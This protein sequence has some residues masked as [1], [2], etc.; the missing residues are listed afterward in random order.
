ML[1]WLSEADSSLTDE[2]PETPA[3]V[4]AVRAFK[5]ALFGTPHPGQNDPTI[6]ENK[7]GSEEQLRIKRSPQAGISTPKTSNRLHTSRSQK[8][9]SLVSPAKGILLTPGTAA[10]R[11]K[12]VSFSSL[13]PNQGSHKEDIPQSSPKAVA[14]SDQPVQKILEAE[15]KDTT[16]KPLGVTKESF[17]AQLDA[18]KQRLSGHGQ[19]TDRT[20]RGVTLASDIGNAATPT[21]GPVA[22]DN[23]T[24]FTVDL[25]K[26]RSKSGQYWKAEHER[27]QKESSRDL[28]RVLRRG[29]HVKSFAEKKDSE[30]TILQE[31]LDREL[32][33]C[34]KMESKVSN[35]VTQLASSKHQDSKVSTDQESLVNELSQQTAL[36][37]RYKQKADRYRTAIQ[38]QKSRSLHRARAE[39]PSVMDSL[40]SGLASTSAKAPASDDDNDGDERPELD[41]LRA[42]MQNLRSQLS[43]AEDRATKLEA[44]NAKLTKNFL[45]VK[46]EM[47][48]YDARRVRKETM[49]K[50]REEQFAAELTA[51]KI[52]LSQLVEENE[53]LKHSLGDQPV[54]AN[55]PESVASRET[56][57]QNLNKHRISN[58]SGATG[59][60]TSKY[61]DLPESGV[62]E[63][64][65]RARNGPQ[66]RHPNRST[67]KGPSIDIWTMDS[68]T[69]TAEITPPAAEP[70][71]NLSS[72]PLSEAT[73]NALREI[74]RNSLSEYPPETT[75]P[76]DTP[77]PT[78]QH[79]ATMDSSLQPDFPSSSSAAYPSS[80]VK[81]VNDRK[82]TIASPR[83]SMVSMASSVVKE[84]DTPR[85]GGWRRDASIVS[86]RR[87]TMT[88]GRSRFGELPPERAAAAKARLAQRKNLKENRQG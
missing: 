41:D 69:S 46:N 82:H 68:P 83:P 86:S 38:Q 81:R 78:L 57:R 47:H 54:I 70:A 71:I 5:T 30:V 87:S 56:D 80:A 35:L 4:F 88:G 29:Q 40:I 2:P 32:A 21:T 26:P 19:S 15:N 84:Q 64:S 66:S 76:P 24:E 73:H 17:E 58:S 42:E 9:K 3:P 52:R 53:S 61:I 31:R 6:V 77:R 62:E 55:A 22:A 63:E 8:V 1:S 85:A 49:L 23:T 14:E 44:Q 25:A 51:C 79:L 7:V 37:I 67:S 13:N 20:T 59:V 72:V 45:R 28:K 16:I 50:Q 74:D 27:Y 33:K 10:A 39:E 48:N 18:S 34:A 11:R 12:T 65:E 43:N 36:A 60:G 75:L